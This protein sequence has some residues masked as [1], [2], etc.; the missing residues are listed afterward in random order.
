VACGYGFIVAYVLVCA[1]LP[2]YLRDHNAYRP[3]AQLIPWLACFAMLLALVG[4]LYPV[5]EGPYGKPPYVYLGYLLA[6]LSWFFIRAR[7]RKPALAE[8]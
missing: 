5:P 6:G 8:G 7:N 4:K 1:A 2:R 3:G